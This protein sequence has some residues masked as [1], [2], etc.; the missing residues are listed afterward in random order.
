MGGDLFGQRDVLM[1]EL[2]LCNYGDGK[3]N[4]FY[5]MNASEGLDLVIWADY[6]ILCLR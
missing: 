4:F 2:Y 6:Y 3:W 1:S 5:F